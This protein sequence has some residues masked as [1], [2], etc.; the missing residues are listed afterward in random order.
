MPYATL[1]AEGYELVIR[2]HDKATFKIELSA[3]QALESNDVDFAIHAL[4]AL[5]N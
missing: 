3:A 4:L 1:F 5:K 2:D